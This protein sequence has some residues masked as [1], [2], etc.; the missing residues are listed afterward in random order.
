MHM[1]QSST[2]RD[3]QGSITLNGFCSVMSMELTCLWPADCAASMRTKTKEL[4][5]DMVFAA[6]A[7]GI[8]VYLGLQ[9]GR[10]WSCP[11]PA[12]TAAPGGLSASSASILFAVLLCFATAL[13]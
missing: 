3:W 8:I 10:P 12:P 5:K 4:I 6:I 1:L 2:S 11:S 7:I 13:K 9:P